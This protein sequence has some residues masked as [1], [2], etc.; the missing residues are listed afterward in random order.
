MCTP[1][2]LP[3]LAPPDSDSARAL[4]W[5]PVCLLRCSRSVLLQV[6]LAPIA[7]GMATNQFFPKL[8]KVRAAQCRFSC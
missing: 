2:L 3:K 5:P 6:V 7:V 4:G 8:V 1:A